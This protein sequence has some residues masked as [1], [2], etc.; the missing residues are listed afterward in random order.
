MAV[1]KV[2]MNTADGE[3]TLIDLTE[4]T[5]SEETVF[6]GNTFHGANGDVKTGTFTIAEELSDQDS[7]IEQIKAALKGKAT[8]GGGG[9]APVVQPLEVTE[10][11]TYTA[12]DG[13]D[14]YSPIVVAIPE[15]EVI[16][17]DLEVTEN[18]IYVVD[19]GYDG[20]GQVT[21]SVATSGGSSELPEGYRECDF[22]QFTGNQ[23][24]DTGVVGTQDTQIHTSFVWENSTQRQ[25]FGCASS[26]NK[27]SIT[28]YMNGSWRF[29]A[30]SAS[31]SIGTKN[32]LLPY[33]AL[34]NKTM[35]GITNSATTISGV[36]DFETVGTLLLGGARDADGTEPGV[37]IYGKVYYFYLWQGEEL[38]RKLIPVTD[39]EIYRFWDV[40]GQ[41]FYDSIT[42]TP[43]E[44]GNL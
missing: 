19:A 24:V 36:E 23:W 32:P 10:N 14:G 21:V 3:K 13:V 42:D 7:L 35:I 28:A 30:K 39:G 20:I 15:R 11:G 41:K 6:K 44:G 2:V 8:G 33:A 34:V 25:L 43:L 9:S 26:D 16:L 27:K 4:D 31:K 17:Q 22:I 38:V 40:I 29:G 1:S 37:G 12:P 5:V 18:G